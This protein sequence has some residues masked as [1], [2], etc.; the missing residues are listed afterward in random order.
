[1]AKELATVAI[2]H[3][4]STYLEYIEK[5]RT[6]TILAKEMEKME[7]ILREAVG[8][9][10]VATIMGDVVIT[11]KPS[12][13]LK[14]RELEADNPDLYGEYVKP[15]LV[16]QFD[17]EAFRNEHPALFRQYQSRSFLFKEAK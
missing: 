9:N 5:R 1:M 4:S 13:R 2:D 8:S 17:S 6:I 7:Q 11:N 10:E 14:A 16:D 3:V 15:V 12:K